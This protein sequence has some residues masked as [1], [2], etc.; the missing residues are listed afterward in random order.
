MKG[1]LQ[2]NSATPLFIAVLSKDLSEGEDAF[3]Q[4]KV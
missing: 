3:T 1:A 4:G 2:F